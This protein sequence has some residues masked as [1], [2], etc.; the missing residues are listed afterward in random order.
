MAP[1]VSELARGDDALSASSSGLLEGARFK[2]L[3][4]RPIAVG[5]AGSS[6]VARP[7]PPISTSSTPRVYGSSSLDS[8]GLFAVDVGNGAGPGSSAGFVLRPNQDDFAA[9]GFASPPP[10]A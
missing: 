9:T 10:C 7:D 2:R 6:A 8:T 3:K 5:W 1:G 4:K